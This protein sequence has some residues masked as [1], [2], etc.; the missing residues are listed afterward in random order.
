MDPASIEARAPARDDG[1]A[2]PVERRELAGTAA[3]AAW[4]DELCAHY[5]E[6]VRW[7]APRRGLTLAGRDR[8]TRHLLHELAAM[9]DPR[10][11][12]VRCCDGQARSFHEFTLRFR[13]VEPGIDGV[14]LRPGAEVE[15]ER[16]RVL[17][18]DP[19]GRVVVET[20]IE[21]WTELGGGGVREA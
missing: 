12:V 18:S 19:D 5:A 13:L 1:A 7:A 17:T 20:C 4:L 21:T 10:L 14:C 15:L 11:C 2:I 6:D 9:A 3:V 8:V 16:L